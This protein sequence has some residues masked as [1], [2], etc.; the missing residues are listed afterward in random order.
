MKKQI[1]RGTFET[2]SSST[3][4]I[5]MCMKSEFDRWLIGELILDMWCDQLV[6]ITE[7]VKDDI[8]MNYRRYATY[9]QFNDY[10]FMEYETFEQRFTTAGNEEIVC[11]GY[12]GY[13]G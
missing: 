9:E 3:H 13:N 11:F 6:E 12:Y 7:E 2:N 10:Y 1:R 4:S 5:T 8:K